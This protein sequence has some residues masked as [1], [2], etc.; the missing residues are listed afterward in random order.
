MNT[1]RVS[2]NTGLLV[3]GD[4]LIFF[5]SLWFALFLR[6]LAVPQGTFYIE[7]VYPFTILFLLWVLIF[8]IAGLYDEEMLTI[9]RSI[10]EVLLV[11]Q[12][13][14]AVFAIILFYLL[15]FF[16]KITPKLSLALFL[17][18]FSIAIWFWRR[19]FFQNLRPPARG[20][21][22]IGKHKKLADTFNKKNFYGFTT[23]ATLSWPE[24]EQVK[25]Y[26]PE[27]IV[28]MNFADG[29]FI[30]QAESI[31]DLVFQDYQ[32]IDS[33]KISERLFRKIE[34]NQVDHEWF[35]K[36]IHQ[37][38]RVFQ[39]TKRIIDIFCGLALL[40]LLTCLLPFISI[41]MYIEEENFDLFFSHKRIGRF[42]KLFTMHKLRSMSVKDG[43]S[44]DGE[45]HQHITKL[46]KIIRAFRI[47]ELPQGINLIRGDLSLVGPRAILA[48]EQKEMEKHTPFY[49]LRLF[50]QPG[51]TGWAQ[52]KQPHAPM[53]KEE[54]QERLSYDLYYM[55]YQSLLFDCAIIL[56]T[57]RTVVLKMGL[58]SK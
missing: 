15:P 22:L 40:I 18:V 43:A 20:V 41:G 21:I 31:H 33:R 54:A 37:P 48:S 39:F 5:C 27:T 14:G 3:L 36:K 49:H 16:N 8:F 57:I 9:R 56:K 19:Y 11:T 32:V 7:H 38:N 26:P 47:D 53:S 12:I 29:E 24:L 1:N 35:L 58:R 13:T 6:H 42:G 4:A 50:A 25:K 55:Q 34:L 30:E 46:G 10:K 23:I 28:L 45:N 17:V 2:L 52:I 44:W 51:I